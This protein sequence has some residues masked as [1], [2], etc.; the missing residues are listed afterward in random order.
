MILSVQENTKKAQIIIRNLK[1]NIQKGGEEISRES[2][3]MAA[4]EYIKS[5]RQAGIQG[6][7]GNF[8][9][10]LMRQ[11]QQPTRLGKYT[12]G[13]SIAA[14]K[15]GTVNYFVALDRMRPHKVTLYKN[16]IIT[17][18]AQDAISPDIQ[19]AAKFG[20]NIWVQPHPFIDRAN[21]VIIRKAKRIARKR[22]GRK[23]RQSKR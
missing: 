23:V 10:M 19:M 18:W 12:Y 11:T 5:A 8:Y 21:K 17:K 4:R 9:G 1:T 16:R 14:T 6:W 20:A 13:I 22:S 2:A 7:R 15:R 3:K